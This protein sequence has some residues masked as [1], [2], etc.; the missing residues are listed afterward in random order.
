[1]ATYLVTGVAGFVGSNLARALLGRGHVVHG[2]DNFATG[3]RDNLVGLTSLRFHE[4]DINDTAVLSKV[5]RG[6]DFV[7]HQAAIPSV[8]RSVAEPMVCHQANVTGTLSVL[9]ACRAAGV[10][11]VV[12]AASSSAYGDTDVL[13]KHEAMVPAPLS[14]YAVAKLAGEYYCQ[15]YSRVYDLPCVVLRYFN[16]FGPYQDPASRYAAVIPKFVQCLL[17]GEP[18]PIFGSGEQTRDFTFIDNVVEANLAACVAPEAGGE[19][20]NVACG[21][22]VSLLRLLEVL[23]ELL[24]TDVLPARLPTR[25]GDVQHSLADITKAQKLLGYRGGIGLREGLARSI[26]WYRENLS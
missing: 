23:Q 8:P 21:A 19:V 11:R 7:L 4:G 25:P 16:V 5:L 2:I 9:E 26:A 22:R 17:R 24:R 18:P 3:K 20:F 1:M 13:P 10:A 14:P 15:V 6:V 12:Y